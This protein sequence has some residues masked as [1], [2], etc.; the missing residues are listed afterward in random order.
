MHELLRVTRVND[1]HNTTGTEGTLKFILY[2][3]YFTLVELQKT[4]IKKCLKFVEIIVIDIC[5]LVH[6]NVI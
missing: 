2:I 4:N 6:H 5:L 3:I 1:F